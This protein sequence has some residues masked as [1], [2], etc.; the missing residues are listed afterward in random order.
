M[1][2]ALAMSLFQPCDMIDLLGRG[3][4]LDIGL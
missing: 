4:P 3:A 1:A 2:L